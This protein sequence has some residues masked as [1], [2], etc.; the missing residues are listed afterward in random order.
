MFGKSSESSPPPAPTPRAERNEQSFLQK[1]VHIEGKV[2]VDGDLRIEGGAKGALQVRGVLMVG[3][4][5]TVEGEV[6]AREV[7][8]HG[9]VGGVVR[10]DERI[11]LA[12]GANVR[13][14]LY[15]RSLVIEEGV[16]FEGRSHMGEESRS[17][18]PSSPLREA[19]AGAPQPKRSSTPAP[20]SPA[21]SRA[22]GV[23]HPASGRTPE[24]ETRPVIGAGPSTHPSGKPRHS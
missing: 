16:F 22:P 18:A 6:H 10:A 12:R 9:R 2:D 13:S 4:G 14:D 8:I 15:C 20:A 1:G 3:S 24:D 23:E 5:A 7:V 17:A 19:A 11:Q 21:P